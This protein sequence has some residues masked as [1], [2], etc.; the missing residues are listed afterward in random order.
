MYYLFIIYIYIGL[1]IYFIMITAASVYIIIYVCIYHL[2]GNYSAA[3]LIG[4]FEFSYHH[5]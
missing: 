1:T 2:S 3:E 4:I 5:I